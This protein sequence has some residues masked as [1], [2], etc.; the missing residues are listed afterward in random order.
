LW[1]TSDT[2]SSIAAN[3]TGMVTV[4]TNYSNGCTA[5]A[6]VQLSNFPLPLPSFTVNPLS[7]SPSGESIAFTN[8][9]VGQN[10]ATITNSLWSYGDGASDTTFNTTHIYNEDGT[11]TI[12]LLVT[13]SDGCTDTIS[14]DY[15][16]ISELEIPN[17]ITPNGDGKN[18]NL[19]FK[20]LQYKS[21]S[22]LTVFN[23]WGNKVYE[24]ADY[25]NDWA[26]AEAGGVYY[27][28]LTVQDLPK[29]LMGY[30]HVMK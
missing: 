4:T 20:N 13:S 6:S 24:S 27:Y 1:S 25:K 3:G 11:Y 17:V 8:T 7:P 29:P 22:E 2:S 9:S 16:I 19:V 21:N 28:I 5:S 12:T 23:R 30:F 14:I 18:D 10:G 15:D 26:P